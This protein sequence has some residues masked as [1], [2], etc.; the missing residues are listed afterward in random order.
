MQRK[1]QLGW[2]QL[3]PDSVM[4]A[5]MGSHWEPGAWHK[6]MDMTKATIAAGHRTAFVEL[7]DRCFN[8]YD[9]LGSMRNEA[10]LMAQNA[11]FEWLCYLDNDVLPEP[12]TLLRL[13]NR[14]LPVIAP[15]VVEPGT[16]T[17]LHGPYR[18][19]NSGVQ[20]VRWTVLSMLLFHTNVFHSTGPQFWRDAIGA[21]EG[22]HFQVLYYYG[23]RLH[24]DTDV[25][26]ATTSRPNYPLALNNLSMAERAARIDATRVA[27]RKRP[28]RRPRDVDN[29][30]VID[31][32]YMP[33]EGPKPPPL[34]ATGGQ[35]PVTN[36]VSETVGN[37]P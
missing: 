24:L 36:V 6:V 35:R 13:L 33:L 20:P 32:V 25:Q 1:D 28:D 27:L 31:S 19:P 26:V 5:T 15:Y 30:H 12:D 34:P 23:H 9:A 14:Q 2:G 18:E 3:N 11:G 16:G 4:I 17:K 29:P 22:Y 7:Q 8:P 21:D 37:A 10:I